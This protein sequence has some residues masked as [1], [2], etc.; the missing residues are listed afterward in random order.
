MASKNS[1]YSDLVDYIA[2]GGGLPI[3]WG[4]KALTVNLTGLNDSA[5]MRQ[6]AIYALDTWAAVSGFRFSETTAGA[7]I[8]FD[9][10]VSGA[11][12][13]ST[14]YTWFGEIVSSDINV[15]KD[16]MNDFPVDAR[17]GPGSYGVQT[18]IHE[19]GHALGL[20]H[21]GPYDGTGTYAADAIFTYDTNQYSVMSYFEQDQLGGA[22]ALNVMTPMKADFAALIELY[23]PL[24]ANDG[25]TNYGRSGL[26]DFGEHRDAAFTIYDSSGSKDLLDLRDLNVGAKIDM[27]PGKFSDINGHV[28]NLAIAD[29]TTIEWLYGSESGDRVVGNAANNYIRGFSG[30]DRINGGA[31]NDTLEGGLGA[32]VLTGGAGAD[33]F[34]YR[35]RQE[36]VS[37]IIMDFVSGVDDIRLSGIDADIVAAGHQAFSFIGTSRFS[38][39]AG[40]LRYGFKD[41]DTFITADLNGDK[42]TDLLFKLD[43]HVALSAGDFLL[44]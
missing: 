10:Q 17:W 18:F 2:T 22:S 35:T 23:G 8:T 42:A 44:A 1:N 25:D 37:D 19:I 11:A 3:A 32:D 24:W 15:G 6:A 7:D 38:G 14:S 26:Y 20:Q 41:G 9:N 36:T 5:P 40:Q 28:K 30:A 21:P 43:G 12:Y 34:A 39:S 31:G 16:W 4:T 29:G 33:I 27:R 13:A